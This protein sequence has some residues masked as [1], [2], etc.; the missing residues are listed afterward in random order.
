MSQVQWQEEQD[1]NRDDSAWLEAM[2]ADHFDPYEFADE[3]EAHGE[4]FDVRTG[5][6][7]QCPVFVPKTREE[8]ILEGVLPAEDEPPF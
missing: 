6:C 1:Y 4:V 3:C 5:H 7:S 2:R 8:L